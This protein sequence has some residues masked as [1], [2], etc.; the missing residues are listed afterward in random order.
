[1]TTEELDKLFP[2]NYKGGAFISDLR[3]LVKSLNDGGHL[4]G[5]P[6]PVDVYTKPETDALLDTKFDKAGGAITGDLNVGQ[7]LIVN[8]GIQTGLGTSGSS[9][10]AFTDSDSDTQ[11]PGIYWSNV[12]KYFKITDDLMDA[13]VA[14][15]EIWHDGN[16]KAADVANSTE[17]DDN[18]RAINE[19]L[20]SLRAAGIIG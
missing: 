12:D 9:L 1:M 7:Y 2:P 13:N 15:N 14:S 11:K 10:I 18:A 5:G 19:L 4:G 8:G 3:L 20:D 17:T 16:R 6:I